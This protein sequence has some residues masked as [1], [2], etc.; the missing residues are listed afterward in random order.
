MS[1]LTIKSY[2]RDGKE[3]YIVA[4]FM[5]AHVW[6]IV[7]SCTFNDVWLVR[8]IRARR[9]FFFFEHHSHNRTTS[10]AGVPVAKPLEEKHHC[11]EE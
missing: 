8:S 11:E 2:R 3:M 5:T 10:F 4:H 7:A 9:P 6:S 1:A